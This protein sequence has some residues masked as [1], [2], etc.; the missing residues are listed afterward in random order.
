MGES[1]NCAKFPSIHRNGL[2]IRRN[3]TSG[4]G[5]RPADNANGCLIATTSQSVHENDWAG[6]VNGQPI[7]RNRRLD[8]DDAC[9][10]ELA[11]SAQ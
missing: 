8:R 4:N 9:L 2:P 7:R 11:G 1:E 5:D 6:P 3:A 10:N